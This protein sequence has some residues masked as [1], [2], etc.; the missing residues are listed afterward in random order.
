[1]KRICSVLA[2]LALLAA[3]GCSKGGKLEGLVPVS[4]TITSKGSPVEG[5][6]VTFSPAQQS[7][8]AQMRAASGMTDKDGKFVLTTLKSQDGAFPGDYRVAV[9]KIETK[10]LMTSEEFYA[11]GKD[12]YGKDGRPK[13]VK[14]SES[15]SLLPEKYGDPVKSGLMATVKQGDKNSFNFPVD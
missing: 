15:K 8:P 1:V 9:T 11:K 2:C 12:V 13:P 4:G 10:I 14:M 5:A 6:A 7:G 3:I